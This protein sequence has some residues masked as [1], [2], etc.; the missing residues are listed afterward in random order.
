MSLCR[1][2]GKSEACQI[3]R[4][5]AV[6]IDKPWNQL[7]EHERRCRKPMQQE[8]D[9]RT[10]IAGRPVEDLDTIRFDCADGCR[11]HGVA[12]F[13]ALSCCRRSRNTHEPS[14][15][16]FV[17]C[18]AEMCRVGPCQ[19]MSRCPPKVADAE[20]AWALAPELGACG[21]AARDC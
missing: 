9:R 8:N 17:G 13:C 21:K 3:R 10:R 7:A 16:S 18:A 4:D 1:N 14:P 12:G 19:R 6:L 2:F 5:D 15:H 20:S 11:R